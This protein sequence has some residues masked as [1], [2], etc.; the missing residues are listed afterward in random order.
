MKTMKARFIFI[1]CVI[2]T[3][4]IMG[5]TL[6]N[7]PACI[8]GA[9]KCESSEL[10]GN[11]VAYLCDNDGNWMPVL[12]CPKCDGNTC[13]D[14]PPVIDC[15]TDGESKCIVTDDIGIMFTCKQQHWIPELC[16]NPV[17]EG[18]TCAISSHK[19]TS[20]TQN[21]VWIDVFDNAVQISCMDENLITTFC[22]KGQVCVDDHCASQPEDTVVACGK[23]KIDCTSIDGWEDGSCTDG[24]CIIESCVSG[25]HLN[26]NSHQCELN[27]N[28]NCGEHGRT[29]DTN[30]VLNS[31]SVECTQAGQCIPLTC[32]TEYHVYETS[33]ELN[34]N[35]N[36]G[37]H[38][39]SCDINSVL[40]STSVECT[41]TGHCMA[42]ACDAGFHVFNGTCEQDDNSNCGTHD[43]PCTKD[44]VDGSETVSCST[45]QCS[46]VTCDEDHILNGSVCIDKACSE[47]ETK[48]LNSGTTGKMYTCTGNTFVENS[49][50]P[51]ETSCKSDG[52]GCG[53][54]INDKK[55]CHEEGQ[56]GYIQTCTEGVWINTKTC[57]ASCNDYENAIC[58]N[59]YNGNSSCQNDLDKTGYLWV[60]EYGTLRRDSACSGNNSCTYNGCGECLN[61]D[62]EYVD[63]THIKVCNSGNWNTQSCIPSHGNG[64]AEDGFCRITSCDD[65]YCPNT[66]G[67]TLSPTCSYYNLLTDIMHCGGCDI[68]CETTLHS[69]SSYKCD[70][71]TCK[72]TECTKYYHLS[73]DICI[74]DNDNEHCGSDDTNCTELGQRCCYRDCEYKCTTDSSCGATVECPE[75]SF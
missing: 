41:Q 10:L 36:C 15:E 51:N 22:P 4:S 71:G 52:S 39:A 21:C 8:S 54:C 70:S 27:D 13:G 40:N 38:G 32:D 60:C 19:C 65:N 2:L 12:S 33:C 18:N 56:E 28:S 23:T 6:G 37:E 34:D 64:I 30:S 69:A 75:W 1:L 59:C 72:A 31:T 26:E 53:D 58:S 62:S 7:P 61:G 74:S 57:H 5:C 11:A 17:C 45:G 43:T 20:G 9:T 42:L 48:C 14:N 66:L 68:N 3:T 67:D 49:T 47:N 50:C 24:E 16:D 46:A 73:N 55:R 25:M 29:C 44:Q 63:T 35:S